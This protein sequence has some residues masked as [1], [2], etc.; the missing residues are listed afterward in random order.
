MSDCITIL[1]NAS[2]THLGNVLTGPNLRPFPFHIAKLF[3]AE[4]FEL[5]DLS[6]L[7]NILQSLEGG[8]IK[9]V[10][11]GRVLFD[12]SEIIGRDKETI[13]ASH[14]SW[15]MIDIDSLE[16]GADP[17]DQRAMLA[18]LVPLDFVTKEKG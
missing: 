9:T 5:H 14:S 4:E 2:F 6:S 16:R 11:R 12:A 7:I 15:C 18:P 8:P 1:T 10:S 13:V 17:K 3:S